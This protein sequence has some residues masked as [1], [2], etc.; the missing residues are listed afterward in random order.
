MTRKRSL[1][2]PLEFE[3]SHMHFDLDQ[4]LRRKLL[5][6]ENIRRQIA[7]RAYQLYLDRG[8]VDGHHEQDWLQAETEILEPILHGQMNQPAPGA[9]ADS[10]NRPSR[11][12]PKAVT[13]RR[14][15]AKTATAK[16]ALTPPRRPA[17]KTASH[18]R[19]G[20]KPDA[21]AKEA[22]SATGPTAEAPKAKN[23]RARSKATS[24]GMPPPA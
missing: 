2:T 1:A 18:R 14:A 8:C 11:A 16:T 13:K 19:A 24:P 23:K 10:A 7:E 4:I 17:A 3:G 12:T 15:S 9:S 5:E 21:T 6:D 22:T 20:K